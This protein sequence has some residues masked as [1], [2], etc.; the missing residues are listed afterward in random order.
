MAQSAINW[1]A[2]RGPPNL[3]VSNFTA[4]CDA[5]TSDSSSSAGG[6][7]P[8]TYEGFT[9]FEGGVVGETFEITWQDLVDAIINLQG[10]YAPPILFMITDAGNGTIEIDGNPLSEGANLFQQGETLTFTPDEAGAPVSMFSVE[11]SDADMQPFALASG[12]A[13]ATINVVESSSMSSA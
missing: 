10:T 13:V 3:S 8:R 2:R 9:A 4:M 11:I 12:S 6:D 1:R 5:G 7:I